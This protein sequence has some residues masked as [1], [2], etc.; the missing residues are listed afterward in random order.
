[1]KA[2][3]KPKAIPARIYLRYALLNTPGLVL[4]LL[5][6]LVVREYLELPGWFMA[7]L[8]AAWIV[9]DVVLFPFIW[10]SYDWDRPG[11]SRS[12]TGSTGIVKQALAPRGF[13]Q[14]NGELWRAE[15]VE[16]EKVIE[17]GAT[18]RVVHRIG[19]TVQVVPHEPGS[20]SDLKPHAGH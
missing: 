11:I 18:V 15:A 16:R 10:R 2:L 6:L 5:I 9:K 12:M 4:L 3:N 20:D 7:L 8:V 13:V 17:R 19:L 14:I 1:M